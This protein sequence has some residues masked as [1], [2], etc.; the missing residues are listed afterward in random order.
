[1]KGLIFSEPM[2]KAW[3]EERKIYVDM[4]NCICYAL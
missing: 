4:V 2:V 3:M 1:M